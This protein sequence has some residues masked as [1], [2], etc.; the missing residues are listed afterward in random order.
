M[1]DFEIFFDLLLSEPLLDEEDDDEEP[2]ELLELPLEL[3][4]SLDELKIFKNQVIIISHSKTL[5]NL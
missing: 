4:E 5:I 3:E 2:E 1:G